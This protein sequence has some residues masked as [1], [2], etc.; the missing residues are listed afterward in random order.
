MPVVE[1]IKVDSGDAP[2]KKVAVSLVRS[3]LCKQ[4][5]S[6]SIGGPAAA[7]KVLGLPDEKLSHRSVPCPMTSLLAWASRRD[8]AADADNSPGDDGDSSGSDSDAEDSGVTITASQGKL[9]VAQRTHLLYRSRCRP[10]NTEHPFCTKNLTSLG[11]GRCESK[12][13]PLP[14]R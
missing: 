10:G 11:A 2:E 6:L 14:A 12:S 5:S 9:T 8:K 7:S 3:C 1:R 4:L 13:A